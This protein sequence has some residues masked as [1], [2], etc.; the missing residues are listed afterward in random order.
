MSTAS[1]LCHLLTLSILLLVFVTSATPN[2]ITC[3]PVPSCNCRK[4]VDRYGCA[5]CL[6][7]P[8][9]L[10]CKY[11]LYDVMVY[12]EDRGVWCPNDCLTPNSGIVIDPYYESC[13]HPYS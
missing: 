11:G 6:C 7:P 12:D 2:H 13:P 10:C 5:L 1:S 3:D 9:N 8:C 4:G